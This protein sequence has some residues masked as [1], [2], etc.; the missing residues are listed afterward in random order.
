LSGG[1]I[2][3]GYWRTHDD[4]Q[5][6]LK[7][8]LISLVPEHEAEIRFYGSLVEKV[9]VL[10]LDPLKE[11]VAPMYSLIG[12]PAHNQPELFRALVV[13][14][15]C[16][17]QDPT[18]FVA[19][20][21]S[22]L[23]LAAICGFEGQTP[24]VG[25]FYDLLAR[26]WLADAPQKAVKVPPSKG[27]KRPKSGDKL[28]PKHPGII[29]K[30][31]DKALQG[32]VI[33]KRPER[34]L[35]A[36]LKECAVIP[37]S[38]LGLLGNPDN[39]AISGD[40][41]PVRTGASPRGKKLCQCPAQGIY[42]CQCERSFT[43]PTANWGWDSYHEQWFYGHTLYS[44]TS[45][46]SFNDLP[47][48]LRFVQGS[49]HDSVTF[50]FAWVEL[51]K[52]YPEFKFSKALLDSAHDVYDIYRLLN[53]NHTQAFIDLNK[54][55][56]GHNIYS[57]PL[58]VNDN[59]VPICIANLPMLNWGFNNDRCRIK[60]RCPH[61]KDRS[62]CPKSPECSPSKYGRVVYTKPDWDL[63]IFTPIPRGSKAWKAIYARRSTVERTFK[64]ILVDYK[65]ENARCRSNKRWFWQ[66]TIAALNQH[67]DAQVALL[68]PSILSEVG[69]KTI[70]K[71]A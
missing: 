36:I 34:V 31:V 66:A 37:S 51:L 60:W 71:A 62:K 35:Q 67:L 58:T 10:N 48:Y 13:M 3:L 29:K 4:Y 45:A 39:L 40:G 57:G 12:R 26:L 56:K 6:W 21:R 9:Y 32:C 17:T 47:I 41:S 5:L 70:S 43:D 30:L 16:K 11:I 52:L 14:L 46:D 49:R 59:G 23:V 7:S 61:Y 15:H 33:E 28:K 68:K 1:D 50:V 53:A 19:V 64:R 42:H 27:R 18:K 38:K 65:I 24:G 20:L 25:T 22:S 55:N 8:K 2:L 44:I 69:I 54:R 63:R